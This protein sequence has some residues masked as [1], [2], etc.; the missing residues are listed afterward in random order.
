MIRL[1]IFK[2]NDALYKGIEWC[3][4]LMSFKY[5]QLVARFTPVPQTLFG[6]LL[7]CQPPVSRAVRPL[8]GCGVA[9]TSVPQARW[10]SGAHSGRS[11]ANELTYDML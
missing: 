2:V 1:K 5:Q 6:E 4:R 8:S 9:Y 11:N 7:D 3:N 10:H